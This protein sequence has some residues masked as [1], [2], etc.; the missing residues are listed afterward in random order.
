MIVVDD[1]EDSEY[2]ADILNFY[3]TGCHFQKR[4]IIKKAL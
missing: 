1:L 2:L 3:M 4:K